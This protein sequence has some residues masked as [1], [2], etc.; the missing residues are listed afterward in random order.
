MGRSNLGDPVN[1]AGV[2]A[3]LSSLKTAYTRVSGGLYGMVITQDVVLACR[4][5]RFWLW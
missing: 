4:P 2:G 1:D 5:I 3:R